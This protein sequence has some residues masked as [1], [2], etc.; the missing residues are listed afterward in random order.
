MT[1]SK[2]RVVPVHRLR[3]ELAL[4]KPLPL[5]AEV[6]HV[7]GNRWNNANRNLVIC[8]DLAYHRL[9][10]LRTRVLR[11]GGDPNTQ[12]LCGICKTPKTFSEMGKSAQV[13]SNGLVAQCLACK[14]EVTRA[15]MK[16]FNDHIKSL[17]SL[18]CL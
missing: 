6:H 1:L 11:A 3:A 5:G 16:K 12:R 9:L 14:R 18:R 7:D 10:H 15:R 4:G 2:G 13:K 8:Q 17:R